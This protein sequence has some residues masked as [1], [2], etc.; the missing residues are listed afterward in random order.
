MA[1]CSWQCQLY[2]HP[3]LLLYALHVSTLANDPN[4]LP[5]S[6]RELQVANM[7]L[8]LL[9]THQWLLTAL[10]IQLEASGLLFPAPYQGALWA[11]HCGWLLKLL[12]PF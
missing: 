3:A 2:A 5:C 10:R 7:S 4:H 12:F 11:S 9:K 8:S 6:W 1:L